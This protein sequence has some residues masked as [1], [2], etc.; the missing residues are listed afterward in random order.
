ML[1]RAGRARSQSTKS[2]PAGALDDPAHA[3]DALSDVV[4]DGKRFVC[5]TGIMMNG[6]SLIDVA[7][8]KL[9]THAQ[10]PGII[11]TLRP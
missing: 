1:P 8:V 7:T 10:S 3:D 11:H 2:L 5:A 9:A 6:G 4:V